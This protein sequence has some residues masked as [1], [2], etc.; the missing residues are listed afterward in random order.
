LQNTLSPGVQAVSGALPHAPPI[1][2]TTSAAVAIAA[3]ALAR[4][5]PRGALMART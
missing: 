5:A 4:F 1:A 2:S 3:L